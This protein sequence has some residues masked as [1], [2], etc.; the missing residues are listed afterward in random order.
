MTNVKIGENLRSLPTDDPQSAG[1]TNQ[2]RTGEKDSQSRDHAR[3]C[4]DE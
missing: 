3:Q 4:N 1:W 2:C